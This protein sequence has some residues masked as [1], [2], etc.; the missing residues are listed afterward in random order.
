MSRRFAPPAATIALAGL[1]TLTLTDAAAAQAPASSTLAITA[2][3][4]PAGTRALKSSY[5]VR[6]S[7][8]WAQETDAHGCL[9]GGEETVEGTLARASDGSYAGTFTRRTRLLF[10]GAHGVRGNDAQTPVESCALTLEG[11]GTVAMTGAVVADETSPSGRSARVRWTPGP[12]AEVTVTGACPPAFKAAVDTMYRTATHGVE[13]PLTT[14]GQGAR[15]ERLE[16]YAWKV[17][18]E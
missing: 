12:D 4:V 3:S 1:V 10:C 6:L 2:A 7:S 17:E 14:V 13:F 8:T 15:T 18:V 11:G 9:N 16:N 5:R